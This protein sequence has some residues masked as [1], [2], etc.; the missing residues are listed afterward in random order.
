MSIPV[1][2]L[3]VLFALHLL[4]TLALVVR[5]RELQTMIV[6][7]GLQALPAAGTPIGRFEVT[8][9]KGEVLNEVLLRD[10]TVLVGFFSPNC[11]W[12]EKAR[13]ALLATPPS[14][15][16]LAFVRGD[17][18]DGEARTLRA[19]LE[20]IGRV[21]YTREGDG[22]YRAFQPTGFPSLYLVKNGLVASASHRLS[23]VAA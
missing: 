13:E 12:C 1:V 10:D 4:V 6:G 21:A 15:P 3:I 5:V 17:D 14:V 2:A 18:A 20:Q 11:D 7:E 23:D 16:L 19:S 22:A 8:T 9:P